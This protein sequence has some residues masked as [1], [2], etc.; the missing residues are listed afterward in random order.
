MRKSDEKMARLANFGNSA[1]S[2]PAAAAVA[3][4][5]IAPEVSESKPEKKEAKI[6]ERQET[7][8]KPGQVRR[9]TLIRNVAFTPDDQIHLDRISDLL[10]RGGEFRP[11]ISDV[12]RVALRGSASLNASAAIKMLEDGRKFDGRRKR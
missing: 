2:K 4:P 7:I 9:P 10:V 5:P 11:T 3:K 8:G 12:V 1:G 6:P